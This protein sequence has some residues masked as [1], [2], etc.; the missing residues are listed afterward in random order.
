M[1]LAYG[2]AVGVDNHGD[3]NLG[4][5][6]TFLRQDQ[7]FEHWGI[8]ACHNGYQH[9]T[10]ISAT[11]GSL[12][13]NPLNRAAN[14]SVAAPEGAPMNYTG[15]ITPA[16]NTYKL[17]GG[18]GTLVLPNATLSGGNSLV[19]KNGG[20]V[21][22]SADNSYT[23]STSILNKYSSSIQAQVQLTPLRISA[24]CSIRKLHP[25]WKSIIWLMQES[26]AASGHPQ[27]LLPRIC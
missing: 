13:P 3:L 9:G 2:G 1:I 11:T 22:L 17:G 23:G 6:T 10:R 5:N 18:A 7:S 27:R 14:M 24:P 21:K 25:Y 26:Q 8:D 15:T 19:V 16:G 20:T 12:D 4:T